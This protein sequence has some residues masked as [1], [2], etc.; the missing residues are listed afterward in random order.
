ML[1]FSIEKQILVMYSDLYLANWT[2]IVVCFIQFWSI[3]EN[4]S[5]CNDKKWAVVL[6]KIMVDKAER[7]FDIDLSDLKKDLT[8]EN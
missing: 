6:Q 8:K 2:A 4:E 5:S 1:A 7:H 3:L